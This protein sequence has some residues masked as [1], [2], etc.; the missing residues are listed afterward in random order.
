MLNMFISKCFL[1]CLITMRAFRTEQQCYPLCP[2]G[3]GL[4]WGSP[5]LCPQQG[6]AHRPRLFSLLV[7]NRLFELEAWSPSLPTCKTAFVGLRVDHKNFL[8]SIWMLTLSATNKMP[9]PRS[10]IDF[11][12]ELLICWLPGEEPAQGPTVWMIPTPKEVPICG[13]LLVFV[14]I[15]CIWP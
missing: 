7:P 11:L 1:V 6:C 15:V 14:L 5:A 9:I 13:V 3:S 4:C 2:A 8:C 12:M 10:Y